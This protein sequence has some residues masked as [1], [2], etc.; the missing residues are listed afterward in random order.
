[1]LVPGSIPE[2]GRSFLPEE[3]VLASCNSQV[4]ENLSLSRTLLHLMGFPTTDLLYSTD[5]VLKT[6]KKIHIFLKSASHLSGLHQNL[7]RTLAHAHTWHQKN[8]FCTNIKQAHLNTHTHTHTSQE[9][10]SNLILN[11][12]LYHIAHSWVLFTN[13]SGTEKRPPH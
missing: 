10:K 4:D 7:A 13:S 12:L 2:P 8:C 6:I 5:R 1:M 9:K 11:D 3:P